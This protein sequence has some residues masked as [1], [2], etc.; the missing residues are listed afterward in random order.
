VNRLKVITFLELL[1]K[2]FLG[3]GL[4]FIFSGF[5]AHVFDLYNSLRNGYFIGIPILLIGLMFFLIL[6]IL[7]N[8]YT[9]KP[10]LKLLIALIVIL[11]VTIGSYAL[12]SAIMQAV[13]R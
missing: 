11:L 13:S 8:Y 3:I 10:T 5:I 1:N 2:V 7:R 4:V 6:K 12:F 9:E